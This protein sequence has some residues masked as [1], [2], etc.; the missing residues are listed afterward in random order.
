[1]VGTTLSLFPCFFFSPLQVLVHQGATSLKSV[2]NKRVEA[3]M[4]PLPKRIQETLTPL[5][6]RAGKPTPLRLSFT[7]LFTLRTLFGLLLVPFHSLLFV[8]FLLFCG[9]RPVTKSHP[10]IFVLPQ[11]EDE[12][13]E[14]VWTRGETP[15]LK[16]QTLTNLD[17][18]RT[19]LHSL[20]GS[21]P[22]P[23]PQHKSQEKN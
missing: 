23:G 17:Q 15:S 12:S 7:V 16:F 1:M 18:V 10:W 3:L 21:N 22:S 14:W 11:W 8:P 19:W 5:P 6:K 4:P 9:R 20:F 13:G 2:R